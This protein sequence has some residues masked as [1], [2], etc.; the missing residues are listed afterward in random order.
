SLLVRFWPV[1]LILFG[2]F[3]V[4]GFLRKGCPRSPIG[5]ALLVGIGGLFLINNFTSNNAFQAYGRFW[6]FLLLAFALGELIFQYS[7]RGA[8]LIAPPVITVGKMVVVAS[9]I[10]TGVLSA[11]IAKTNPNFFSAAMPGALSEFRDAIFGKQFTFSDP[12]AEFPF[13]A[14]SRLNI[15][16]SYGD[17]EVH[18]SSSNTMSIVLSKGVRAYDQATAT[19]INGKVKLQVSKT[20]SG[21]TITTNRDE[22]RSNLQTNIIINIPKSVTLQVQNRYG[23]VG[24]TGLTGNQDINNSH[25]S[26]EVNDVQGQIKIVD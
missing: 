18:A 9:L 19:D 6:P 10:A 2:A 20:D 17:V 16:N 7:R 1:L 25:G 5:G 11:R 22:I 21:Y 8:G 4:L 26:V 13:T 3:R 24:I 15:T 14:N 23:H 12:A